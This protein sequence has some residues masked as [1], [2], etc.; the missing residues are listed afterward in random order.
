V[1][2]ARRLADVERRQFARAVADFRRAQDAHER[3]LT[4]LERDP[5]YAPRLEA[6]RREHDTNTPPERRAELRQLVDGLGLLGDEAATGAD[7]ARAVALL[8][9]LV[10]P[11]GSPPYAIVGAMR[12]ML[13]GW[14]VRKQ[15]IVAALDEREETTGAE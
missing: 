10:T 11:R 14:V 3:F 12:R 6:L 5:R 2:L 15:E 8:E 7:L 4:D 1:T 9:P 13:A